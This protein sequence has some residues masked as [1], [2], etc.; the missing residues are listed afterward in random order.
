MYIFYRGAVFDATPRHGIK[1]LSKFV[2]VKILIYNEGLKKR[3][4]AFD[5]GKLNSFTNWG[6]LFPTTGA[7]YTHRGY[8]SNFCSEIRSM[9]IAGD[10]SEVQ[11]IQTGIA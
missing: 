9:P 3:R 6:A 11:R 8:P 2:F 10:N 4:A 5:H 7:S 1:C